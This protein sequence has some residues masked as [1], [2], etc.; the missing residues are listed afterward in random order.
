MKPGPADGERRVRPRL[1]AVPQIEGGSR[2]ASYAKE[3]ARCQR[4]L[5]EELEWLK[6]L[7]CHG[8]ELQVKWRP[9]KN[10][11]L[12]G[13][14]RGDR[15][16][17]YE[18]DIEA[19]VETLKHEFVD[20]AISKVIEPHVQMTNKLVALLNERAYQQKERLVEELVGLL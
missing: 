10:G 18:P 5:E 13:E 11:R 1:R 14:V 6:K 16:Y 3:A 15:I 17:V 4:R 7:L 20:Y 19:A 8:Q 12:S 2:A 9:E